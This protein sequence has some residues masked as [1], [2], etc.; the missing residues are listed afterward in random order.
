VCAVNRLRDWWNR[1]KE[2]AEAQDE[3]LLSA[4]VTDPPRNSII[5]FSFEYRNMKRYTETQVETVP[6]LSE[7]SRAFEPDELVSTLV[8]IKEQAAARKGLLGAGVAILWG[9][10]AIVGMFVP[11]PQESYRVNGPW[12]YFIGVLAVVAILFGISM[13]VAN[14]ANRLPRSM[15]V[16]HGAYYAILNLHTAKVEATV[17][18]R[19]IVISYIERTAKALQAIPQA[20]SGDSRT[21]RAEIA[22]LA[23]RK[24]AYVRNL[25]YYLLLP[26][27]LS[28]NDLLHELSDVIRIV[29]QDGWQ[30]LPEA[31]PVIDRTLNTLQRIGYASLA[32]VLAGG[33]IT[34]G[35]WAKYTGPGTYVLSL[36]L[37]LLLLAVLGKLGITLTALQ[38]AAEVA[39]QLRKDGRT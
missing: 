3:R 29:L 31:D 28:K 9:I 5:G 7:L 20:L 36:V 32:L 4:F 26:T 39:S 13:V 8:K 21:A 14:F 17:R 18:P 16:V 19:R 35:L 37:G 38:Q 10:S 2:K 24:A 11:S 6:T 15:L 34:G 12:Y 27:P 25:K 30:T 23:F 22:K 33:L 1:N